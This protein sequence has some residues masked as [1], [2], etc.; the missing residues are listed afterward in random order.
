MKI[1]YVD[2]QYAYGIKEQGYNDIGINGFKESFDELG[3]DTSTFFYDDYL[4]N[5]YPIRMHDILYH[6]FPLFLIP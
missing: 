6:T 3:H 4:N 5:F 1:L 2:L